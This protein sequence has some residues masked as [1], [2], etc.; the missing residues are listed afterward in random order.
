MA[1]VGAVRG[2]LAGEP[3]RPARLRAALL[4]AL[5]GG[6]AA[7][8]TV[9]EIAL[10]L[11]AV[12]ALAAGRAAVLRAVPLPGPLLAFAAW[13][14]ITVATSADPAA[15]LRSA[16][17]LLVLGALWV[18]HAA[19]PDAAAARRFA[20]ALFVAVA[21]VALLAIAQVLGCPADGGYGIRPEVPVVATYFRKCDRA[22]GFF[23]IYM[24]LAGVLAV[25]L[26]LTLPRLRGFTYR[27][28]AGFAW[29]AG[30]VALG[31]TLVRGAWVGF[32]ASAGVT[33]VFA[34]R[35]A[36]AVGTLV[37]VFVLMLMLPG[38][39]QRLHSIG[40]LS[41]KTA[42]ERMGMF[43]A[44]MRLIADHPVVGIG[45]GRLKRV[46]ADYAP[47]EAVR[48][49]TS[50]LH[51]TPL[52]IAVERGLVGLGVWLWIFVAFFVRALRVLRRIPGDAVAD[53]ALVVGALAGV[54]AFLGAGLFEYNFGD[55]EVLLVTLSVMALP[56][57]VERDRAGRAA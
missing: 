20:T 38:V 27:G 17:N 40:D 6:L 13:T 10:A 52:Q 23:S 18:V 2:A 37:G 46:Y 21:A 56:F 32:A 33:L 42:R 50:H 5:A 39:N 14:L 45:P 4:L 51:N 31:F 44:G 11:L 1:V 26:A 36:A 34:R 29:V 28:L 48:R 15:S 9:S 57:V 12:L 49:Q 54:T 53:R 43:V 25:V 22:H 16:R 3:S 35:R 30:I 8:I 19:L 41:D 24:T 7:S 55:T 47:P